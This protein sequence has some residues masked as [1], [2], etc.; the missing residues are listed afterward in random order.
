MTIHRMHYPK[1]GTILA[2]YTCREEKEIGAL[3]KVLTPIETESTG[4]SD[5][6]QKNKWMDI[7]AGSETWRD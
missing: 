5:Y 4:L 2:G 7:K 1:P 6:L 3:K